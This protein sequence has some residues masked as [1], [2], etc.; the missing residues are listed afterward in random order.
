MPGHLN[1]QQLKGYRDRTLDLGE[2]VAVDNH[3][4]GCE[5]CRTALANFAARTTSRGEALGLP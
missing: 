4:G 3:L 5:P 1:E 2:L